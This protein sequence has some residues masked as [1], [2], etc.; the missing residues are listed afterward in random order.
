LGHDND[1]PAED[2]YVLGGQLV[3]D[4]DLFKK[5]IFP[6]G[7]LVHDD[8]EPAEDEYVQGGQSIHDDDSLKNIF[9]H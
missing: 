1:E 4:D 3:H 9:S 8:D 2:E 5:Y 7:H 6:L